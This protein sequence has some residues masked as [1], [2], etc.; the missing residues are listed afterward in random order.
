[1]QFV[2]LNFQPIVSFLFCK[3]TKKAIIDYVNR[4]I[5]RWMIALEVLQNNCIIAIFE[6]PKKY[7]SGTLH[8]LLIFCLKTSEL[9]DLVACTW[10]ALTWLSWDKFELYCIKLENNFEVF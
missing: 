10:D 8:L 7:C 3:S 6:V 9:M 5:W 1:M 2:I 4:V